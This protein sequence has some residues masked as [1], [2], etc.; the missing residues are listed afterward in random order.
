MVDVGER[1]WI[2]QRG[3]SSPIRDDHARQVLAWGDDGQHSLANSTVGVVGCGG[4]GSHVALQLAHLGVGR[5]VLVD[6]DVVEQSNL[7]R[8]VGVGAAWA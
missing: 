6:H 1:V 8:L 4:T 3:A 5:L 2:R 7:S